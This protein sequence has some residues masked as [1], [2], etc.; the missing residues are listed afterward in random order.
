VTDYYALL[1]VSPEASETEIRESYRRLAK[2]YHPDLHPGDKEAEA[3]SKEIGEAYAV[4]I[5]AKSRKAYDKA[6]LGKSQSR[7]N[8]PRRSAAAGEMPSKIDKDGID[9]LF[10]DFFGKGVSKDRQ[11]EKTGASVIDANATFE[12]FFGKR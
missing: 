9:N 8:A 3:R 12:N 1:E 10:R 7:N 2:K 11:K 6:R 4:L 5:G